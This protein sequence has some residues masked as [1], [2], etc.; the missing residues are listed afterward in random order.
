VDE[1][2][3]PVAFVAADRLAGGL[4]EPG[5]AVQAMPGEHG[6]DRGGGHVQQCCQPA[7]AAFE[8]GT[9]GADAGFA[10]GCG[11]ARPP[12]GGTGPVGQAGVAFG[13]PSG[14]PLVAGGARHAEVFDDVRDRSALGQ[15][16]LDE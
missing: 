12:V 8:P 10:F 13:V 9:Q 11:L 3:G 5:E 7:R 1:F 2:A 16:T 14:Q 6:V 15:D 4:V